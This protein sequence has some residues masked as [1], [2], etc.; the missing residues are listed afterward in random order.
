MSKKQDIFKQYDI[1]ADG[2]IDFS[3]FLAMMKDIFPIEKNDN[4]FV[5]TFL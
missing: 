2:T 4:R 3:E 5:N 1:N